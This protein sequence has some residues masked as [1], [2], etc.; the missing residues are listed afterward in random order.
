[1]LVTIGLPDQRHGSTRVLLQFDM[2][3]SVLCRDPFFSG[4]EKCCQGVA[5]AWSP[6]EC[7]LF[8]PWRSEKAEATC[9]EWFGMVPDGFFISVSRLGCQDIPKNGQIGKYFANHAGYR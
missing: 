2:D 5:K 7:S 9:G 8:F 4:I 6:I 3:L 1:V